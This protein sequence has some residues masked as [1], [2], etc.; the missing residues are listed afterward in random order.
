MVAG[1][2]GKGAMASPVTLF[3]GGVKNDGAPN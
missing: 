3:L 1:G 2:E